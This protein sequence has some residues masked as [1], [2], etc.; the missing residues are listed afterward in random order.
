MPAAVLSSA[1]PHIPKYCL[2]HYFVLHV[3]LDYL[4]CCFTSHQVILLSSL[5]ATFVQG[6]VFLEWQWGGL[7]YLR[8]AAALSTLSPSSFVTYFTIKELLWQEPGNFISLFSSQA[9]PSHDLL[10]CHYI[11]L[12]ILTL[13]NKPA[14]YRLHS[15]NS[16]WVLFT[17]LIKCIF[18]LILRIGRRFVLSAHALSMLPFGYCSANSFLYGN[19]AIPAGS[20][21]VFQCSGQ[22]F[23][24]RASRL[25]Q[26]RMLPGTQCCMKDHPWFA[27][28]A[29]LHTH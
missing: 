7:F 24:R 12:W 3:Y 14:R 20:C 8:K 5:V 10:P 4:S 25:P 11:S 18:V 17:Q 6:F 21:L 1:H 28:L 9:L 22:F 29:S 26:S 13:I 16:N 23:H 15:T 19:P 2:S 27:P